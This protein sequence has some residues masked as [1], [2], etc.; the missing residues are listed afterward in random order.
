MNRWS[1]RV[2]LFLIIALLSLI[3]APAL[4][5]YAD[6][7][8]EKQEELDEVQ[9]KLEQYRKKIEQSKKT[10]K[11]VISEIAKL[12]KDI[13]A[14]EKKLGLLEKD[15]SET[16]TKI[17][18]TE[19]LLDETKQA[20]EAQQNLTNS[21]LRAIYKMGSSG[22]LEVLLESEDFTDFISR[23]R[24]TRALIKQDV[25]FINEMEQTAKE[26]QDAKTQLE[27][28]KQNLVALSKSAE[29]QKAN[30]SSRS[31]SRQEYLASIQK[32]R[33]ELE[34][35]EDE[36]L[37]ISKQLES[38]IREMQA[39][40]TVNRTGDLKMMWPAQGP[41]TSY[42]GTRK[43][44]VLG[45]T[46]MHTGLDIGAGYGVAI[47]AA[48]SGIV[49]TASSLSGYGNTVII[50]HGNGVST[51]YGHAS[52]LLVKAGQSVT[53]GQTIAKVGSTGLSTGPHLHFEVRVNGAPVNPLGWL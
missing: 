4:T 5:V 50:N 36:L 47:K 17:K 53:K 46:K 42:F 13:A 33:A 26:Y 14:A 11:S 20:L 12:D 23:L 16:E 38:I 19:Q 24:F 3:M 2:V 28:Q 9:S 15:I 49:I 22:Y 21:R 18:N 35:A 44:P 52:A 37:E 1:K 51:L 31:S 32:Q 48:E 43:H 10:E 8:L 40:Q 7:L 25:G 30:L 6:D 41:I 39:K 34:K 27:I 45:V 29:A